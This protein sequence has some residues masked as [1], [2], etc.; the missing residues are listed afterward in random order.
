ML[1][2]LCKRGME[3]RRK[4]KCVFSGTVLSGCIGAL[5][6][7]VLIGININMQD[8]DALGPAIALMLLPL[9]YGYIVKALIRLCLFLDCENSNY[10]P[11]PLEVNLVPVS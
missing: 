11:D 2:Y 1:R 9:L 7:A 8:L 3:V 10:L 6:G 4:T 5:L